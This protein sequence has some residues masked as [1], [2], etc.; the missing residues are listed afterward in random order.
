MKNYELTVLGAPV[1]FMRPRFDSRSKKT[2]NANKYT[3][4]KN[5]VKGHAA[6]ITEGTLKGPLVA[7]VDFYLPIPKSWTKKR[8]EQARCRLVLPT[9][10]PD[11]DNLQKSVFDACNK[12][13]YEDDAQIVQLSVRKFYSDEP[14]VELRISEMDA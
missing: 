8:Q 10:V 4:Y 13:L 2:F 9:S 11:L 14:R 5:Y 7:S 3:I 12:V 1:A 6:R